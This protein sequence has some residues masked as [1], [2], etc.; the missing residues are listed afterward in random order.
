M[1][2]GN[3]MI[4]LWLSGCS[5]LG[6]KTRLTIRA[7]GTEPKIKVYVECQSKEAKDLARHDAERALKAVSDT[8][9][10]DERFVIEERW[11]YIVQ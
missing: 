5:E 3:L 7:S 4:T 2:E 1:I 11:K 8:W 10:K 6:A 9:F